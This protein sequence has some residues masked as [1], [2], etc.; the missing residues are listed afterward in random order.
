[1]RSD[2]HRLLLFCRWISNSPHFARAQ[3]LW[4][5]IGQERRCELVAMFAGEA[6]QKSLP[7]QQ[8]AKVNPQLLA[9]EWNKTKQNRN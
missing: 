9:S 8:T 3:A 6:K 5:A 2:V 7:S 1:M 4:E